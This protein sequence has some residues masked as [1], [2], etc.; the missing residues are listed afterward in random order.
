MTGWTPDVPQWTIV[1]TGFL[2]GAGLG[3]LFVPLTTVTF[4]TLPAHQ[5]GA[6]TGLYNLSR[7]IGSAIGISVVIALLT[8]NTQANHADI[9]AYVT[10]FNRHFLDPSIAHALSPYTPAGRAALDAVVT[11]QANIIAYINDF[12]LLMLMCLVVMPL[13]LLFRETPNAGG[14]SDHAVVME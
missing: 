14:T 1:T 11:T 12:K 10:P 6:G 8:R 13:L 2:Q 3:F 5:R 7:N 9:A 4:A